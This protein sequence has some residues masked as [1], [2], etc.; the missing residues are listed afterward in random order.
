MS[1]CVRAVRPQA[2]NSAC[3]ITLT[4]TE[5]RKWTDVSEVGI[6]IGRQPRIP[7]QENRRSLPA[8]VHRVVM[9]QLRVVIVAAS[10]EGSIPNCV[11][12]PVLRTIESSGEINPR[13]AADALRIECRGNLKSCD[14]GSGFI[15]AV[16]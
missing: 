5:P 6:T 8:S 1:V 12:R 3:R 16:G 14:V 7:T 4:I 13:N 10:A 11:R 2:P 15:V 9:R